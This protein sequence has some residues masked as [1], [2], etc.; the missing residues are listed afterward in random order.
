MSKLKRVTI[1]ANREPLLLRTVSNHGRAEPR[2]ADAKGEVGDAVEFKQRPIHVACRPFAD[3][4]HE[5]PGL[6]LI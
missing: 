1:P 5:L 3:E 2:L 4:V 6:I